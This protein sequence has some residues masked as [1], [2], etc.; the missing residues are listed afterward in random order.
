[1]DATVFQMALDALYSL[2]Q[3]V[4][5]GYLCIGV[6]CGLVLGV[7]PGLG[8][9]VGLTLLLP[10]TYTMEPVTAIAFLM[11]LSAVT[12]TSDSIPAVLFGVPGTVASAATVM[13]GFP[14]ARKGQAG[15]ALG[16]AFAAS[17][18]GGLFGALVLFFLVPFLRPAILSIAKPEMLAIIIFGISLASALSGRSRLRGLTVACLGLGLAAVGQSRAGELRWVFDTFYLYDGFHIVPVTLGL[19]ALPEIADMIIQR[20]SIARDAT[21]RKITIRDQL[22]GVRDVLRNWFLV[23][24]CAGIGSGLGAIPGIGATVIDWIAYGHAARTCKGASETF[25]RGDVRG[26]IA[27]ESSNN[28][29]EGG[30]LVPTIAFGI[31]GSASMALILAALLAQGIVPGPQM[32]TTGLDVTYSLVW[33]IALANVFAAGLCLVFAN[34]FAKVSLIRIGLLGPTVLVIVYLGAF[35]GKHAWGDI[36]TFLAFGAIGFAMK[37]LEWPRPPLILGIVLGSMLEDSAFIVAN[38]YGWS[39]LLRPI[40]L[41]VLLLTLVGI[42]RP[43]LGQVR[44]FLADRRGGSTTLVRNDLKGS[45][46]QVVFMVAVIALFAYALWSTFDWRFRSALM[47]MTVSVIG[48]A[49]TSIALL[50]TVFRVQVTRADGTIVEDEEGLHL[51]Q[52]TDFSG[53]GR[54]T[55]WK[56][57]LLL[58]GG[59]VVLTLGALVIG[60]LPACVIFLFCYLRFVERESLGLSLAVTLVLM[61]GIYLLFQVVLNVPWAPAWIGNQFPWLRSS[62]WLGVV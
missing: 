24:R 20:S 32:L 29:K 57:L 10:F 48:L 38:I 1:M 9:L 15:R 19:F 28:A 41:G 26:V 11:G 52:T 42:M 35:Q 27:S 18:C 36:Y 50:A 16:A 37:R 40:A 60:V 31:P 44:R 62:P 59:C 30:S 33:S 51:D 12:A 47:P 55:Y 6:L 43:L 45:G 46:P 23:F 8:G 14:M 25:G 58:A 2:L 21:R 56:R 39:W 4:G 13:D 5:L 61:G 49:L 7:I 3:P 54:A 34:Q 17:V 53:L 22:T